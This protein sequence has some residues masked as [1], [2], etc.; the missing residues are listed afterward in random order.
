MHGKG[1]LEYS[2]ELP[3]FTVKHQQHKS[4]EQITLAVYFLSYPKK[5]FA[6]CSFSQPSIKKGPGL[7]GKSS[8]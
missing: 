2:E 5:K 3:K 4:A 8:T 7:H 6:A 1:L